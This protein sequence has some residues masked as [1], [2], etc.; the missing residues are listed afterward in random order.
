VTAS[1]GPALNL[2]RGL[3][4]VALR[5]NCS[6]D[7]KRT[8]VLRAGGV[9]LLIVNQNPRETLFTPIGDPLAP[10][11]CPSLPTFLLSH[12]EGRHLQREMVLFSFFKDI[13]VFSVV[14]FS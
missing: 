9:G 6:F 5:G 13:C 11:I 8:M 12:E 7:T 3:I 2:Y 10:I 1:G 14:I 4:V